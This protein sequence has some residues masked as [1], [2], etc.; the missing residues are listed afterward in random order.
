MRKQITR[1]IQLGT[2]IFFLK[3]P[4]FHV[5]KF[6][7]LIHKH[8]SSFQMSFSQSPHKNMIVLVVGSSLALIKVWKL[9]WSMTL[10][11][12]TKHNN[13]LMC[14]WLAQTDPLE[15]VLYRD[16]NKRTQIHKILK[17][18]KNRFIYTHTHKNTPHP[19]NPW[20]CDYSGMLCWRLWLRLGIYR[21]ERNTTQC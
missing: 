8:K 7:V 18:T 16:R 4:F 15:S 19:T 9:S 17:S 10:L 3:N 2:Y 6:K 1:T 20:F 11:K 14:D 13:P 21:T 12:T 5:S